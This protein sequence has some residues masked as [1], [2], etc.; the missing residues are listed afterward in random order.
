MDKFKSRIQ[1]L[2][3][4]SIFFIYSAI[5]ELVSNNMSGFIIWIMI[6]LFYIISLAILYFIIKKGQKEQKI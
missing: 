1:L 6:S 4:L 3:L 2:S 5:K